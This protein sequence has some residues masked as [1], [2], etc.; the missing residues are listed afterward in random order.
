MGTSDSGALAAKLAREKQIFE[1]CSKQV[2]RQKADVWAF[3]VGLCAERMVSNYRIK[4][5]TI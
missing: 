3:S 5:F 4:K 1:E 2:R